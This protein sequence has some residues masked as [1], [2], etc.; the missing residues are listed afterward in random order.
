MT[1]RARPVR[2]RRTSPLPQGRG[3]EQGYFG[4]V[5]REASHVTTPC[6]LTHALFRQRVWPPLAIVD[7]FPIQGF[8]AI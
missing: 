1:Q 5:E 6:D 8:W 7:G 4:G 2:M 3:E